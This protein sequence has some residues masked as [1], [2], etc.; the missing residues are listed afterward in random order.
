MK[1]FVAKEKREKEAEASAGPTLVKEQVPE[2]TRWAGRD[3]E[4][5]TD[6][7]LRSQKVGP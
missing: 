5:P 3:G 6:D 4:T 1:V 7:A 2:N